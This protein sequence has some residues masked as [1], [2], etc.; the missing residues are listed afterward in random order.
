MEQR[1]NLRHAPHLHTSLGAAQ[2]IIHMRSPS[3]ITI[4]NFKIY[5]W[6]K[7]WL[8]RG[9]FHSPPPVWNP[10]S[11]SLHGRTLCINIWCIYKVHTNLAFNRSSVIQYFK[12]GH[13]L[14]IQCM[15][16]NNLTSDQWLARKLSLTV[17]PMCLK[18]KLIWKLMHLRFIQTCQKLWQYNYKYNCNHLFK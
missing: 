7:L 4:L 8:V 15:R 18:R 10:G 11:Y 13:V 6:G 9:E 14:K 5:G 1:L 2:G 12:C 17:H 3:I 16:Q